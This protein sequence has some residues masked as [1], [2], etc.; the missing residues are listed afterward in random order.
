[1]SA[2]QR[3]VCTGT[4]APGAMRTSSTRTRSFS[5]ISLWCSGAAVTASSESGHGH[6]RVCALTKSSRRLGGIFRKH[7]SAARK[8][9][10]A[11]PDAL[12]RAVDPAELWRVVRLRDRRAH[13]FHFRVKVQDFVTHFAAPPGLLVAAERQSGVEHVV[14]VDPDRAGAKLR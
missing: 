3:C 4:V 8:K 9:R 2:G 5:N 1:M 14:A 11:L 13:G 6:G 7:S 10:T 12:E